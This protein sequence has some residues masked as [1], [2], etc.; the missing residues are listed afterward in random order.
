M[1]LRYFQYMAV[2]LLSFPI[3]FASAVSN[4]NLP[5]SRASQGLSYSSRNNQPAN[6]GDILRVFGTS[7]SKRASVINRNGCARNHYLGM[8]WWCYYNTLDLILPVTMPAI[9]DMER[10]F[11]NVLSLA[12]DVWS[13]KP[14]LNFYKVSMGQI[15]LQ[16]KSSEPIPSAWIHEYLKGAVC[17]PVSFHTLFIDVFA[18]SSRPHILYL[19]SQLKIPYV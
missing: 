19:H 18:A 2:L 8:G 15:I 7:I 17:H 16:M 5:P 1:E 10:F 13:L 6:S 3:T 14:A 11:S 9:E 4:Q 12:G